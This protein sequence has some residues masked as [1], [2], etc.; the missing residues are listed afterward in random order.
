MG[1]PGT[2]FLKPVV[3]GFHHCANLKSSWLTSVYCSESPA[4]EAPQWQVC[5]GGG[6]VGEERRFGRGETRSEGMEDVAAGPRRDGDWTV[7]RRGKM[8]VLCRWNGGLDQGKPDGNEKGYFARSGLLCW[9]S[10]WSYV[11]MYQSGEWS[12][13][14]CR[15]GS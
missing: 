12:L 11:T 3:V 2:Q 4:D 9:R 7:R 14:S 13:A 8:G 6:E 1:P 15:G 5:E 10:K